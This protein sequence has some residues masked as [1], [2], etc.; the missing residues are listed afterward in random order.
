MKI[1]SADIK[2]YLDKY[3]DKFKGSGVSIGWDE[4]EGDPAF[5][6]YTFNCDGNE[7]GYMG[8]CYFNENYKVES[9][10]DLMLEISIPVSL[11]IN[12]TIKYKKNGS[13][14]V[15]NKIAFDSETTFGLAQV[16]EAAEI[17]K[18]LILDYKTAKINERK[19]EAQGDF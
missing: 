2:A 13:K 8:V 11:R 9:I 16:D 5:S 3:I 17:L 12:S 6:N 1:T 10:D 14:T 7:L 19:L 18:G 4:Y 15:K